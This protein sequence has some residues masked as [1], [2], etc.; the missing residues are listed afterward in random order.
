MSGIQFTVTLDESEVDAIIQRATEEVRALAAKSLTAQLI[1]PMVR[2]RIVPQFAASA[3]EVEII[4][5][6]KLGQSVKPEGVPVITWDA[7][8]GRI[9]SQSE[10]TAALLAQ[11]ASILRYRVNSHLHL[12]MAKP[13]AEQFIRQQAKANLLISVARE[14]LGEKTDVT[15]FTVDNEWRE[16]K[17]T[18]LRFLPIQAQSI[19]G[20][21]ETQ[22]LIKTI[23][24][25]PN[26]HI[27]TAIF[28]VF[29]GGVWGFIQQKEIA[30]NG[31][32][33]KSVKFCCLDPGEKGRNA[34]LLWLPRTP[35][36]CYLDHNHVAIKKFLGPTPY[37]TLRKWNELGLTRGETPERTTTKVALRGIDKRMVP[38]KLEALK[39]LGI[40]TSWAC[41]P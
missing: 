3:R 29:K 13:I 34:P 16:H 25:Y 14:F 18:D 35:D 10:T 15:I 26:G 40:D 39:A 12:K 27:L 30:S 32:V 11:K 7:F 2:E 19:A 24:G 28:N 41:E 20:A 17:Y 5:A 9:K 23:A 8:H 37:A 31:R 38:L 6:D 36:L 21:T 33:L 4:G 1:A 22:E